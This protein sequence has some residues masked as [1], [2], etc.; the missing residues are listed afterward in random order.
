M[1]EKA[2][3]R[4][5]VGIFLASASIFSM[6]SN[7]VEPNAFLDRKADTVSAL[8]EE[9]AS[10]SAVL[11]RFERHFGM[12]RE[13][14]L[15]YFGG[16]HLAKLNADG[17]Y[18]VYSVDDQGVIKSHVERLRAGVRVFAD[19]NGI[20]ILKASCGNALTAGSNALQAKLIPTVTGANDALL[21]LTVTIPE[22]QEF[23]AQMP[24]GTPTTPIALEPE[25]PVTG[26][27]SQNV[28]ALP[29]VLLAA[30]SGAGGLSFSSGHSAPVPEPAAIVTMAGLVLAFK[31]RRK[32]R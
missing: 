13:E 12:S 19:S 8:V 10:D 6:A 16:L 30:L 17:V 21:D 2:A 9:T 20:P 32:R 18:K 15:R 4:W 22:S 23:A 25:I 27:N 29:A 31:C 1:I 28:A 5:A 7:R 24:V 11:D 14:L 26:T 3:L